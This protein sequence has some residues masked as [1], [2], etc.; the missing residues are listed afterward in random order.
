MRSISISYSKKLWESRLVS[1]ESCIRKE[2]HE[3][4]DTDSDFDQC[5]DL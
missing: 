4:A 5:S 3:N 1:I 2:H